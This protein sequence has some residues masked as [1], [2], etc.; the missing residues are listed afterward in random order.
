MLW[1]GQEQPCPG[2]NHNVIVLMAGLLAIEKR[3][4]SS[5][6]PP[7][8]HP[9]PELHADPPPPPPPQRPAGC[10]DTESRISWPRRTR[11]PRLTERAGGRKKSFLLLKGNFTAHHRMNIR[12]RMATHRTCNRIKFSDEVCLRN[13]E[14]RSRATGAKP[15]LQNL[16]QKKHLAPNESPLLWSFRRYDLLF[17]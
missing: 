14:I 4:L 11:N 13:E 3:R 1:A 10:I 5:S 12:V 6:P 15:E 9:H 2:G 17:S 8:F 7:F 16:G